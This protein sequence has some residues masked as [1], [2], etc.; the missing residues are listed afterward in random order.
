MDDNHSLP[1]VAGRTPQRRALR[2]DGPG[3]GGLSESRVAPCVPFGLTFGLFSSRVCSVLPL[4]PAGTA[5]R[6]G[7]AGHWRAAV[8]HRTSLS[9]PEMGLQDTP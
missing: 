5:V 3:A 4:V 9:L 8:P 6:A 1:H 2:L 7:G